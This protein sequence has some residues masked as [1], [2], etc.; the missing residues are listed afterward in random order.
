MTLPPARVLLLGAHPDDAEVSAAGLLWRHYHAGSTIRLISVTDGRS[1]HQSMDDQ[2]LIAR[3]RQEAANS[4][5]LL[6]CDYL[7]WDFPDGYLQPTLELR[8]RVIE[9]IRGFRPDLVLT[10][11][12]C[13]Y[14][15]DHRAI[16]QAVQDAS[17]LVTVPKIVP[18]QPAL[19]RDPIVAYMPDTFSRP[20]L[21]RPDFVLDATPYIDDIVRM[22]A[23]HESQ[24]FDWLPY[25]Q[26]ILDS[27]PS[28]A[29][30]RLKW[31]KEWALRFVAP[32]SEL[33]WNSAW[34]P[35]PIWIEA[36]EISEYAG[37]LSDDTA[38]RLFPG[39]YRR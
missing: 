2:S 7:T 18:Q 39:C 28:D 35:K 8:H 27:V 37:K 36:F 25:N 20:A 34:G 6:G 26:G 32:R 38:E 17:Y 31:L 30:D 3:R 11:R 29:G 12:T 5:R 21:L 22:M 24:F 23:C 9:E 4:G 10:H 14:H 19:K 13:D 16:A 33:F 15:P 1:G